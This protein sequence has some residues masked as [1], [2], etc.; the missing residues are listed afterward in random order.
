MEYAISLFFIVVASIFKKL[1]VP[2][3]IGTVVL[4]LA[5]GSVAAL[6]GGAFKL[7]A[8]YTLVGCAVIAVVAAVVAAISAISNGFR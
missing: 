2:V 7:G 5:G 4:T 1:F 6:A 8:I 3:L